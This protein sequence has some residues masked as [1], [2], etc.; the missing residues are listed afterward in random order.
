M[1]DEPGL[2]IDYERDDFARLPLSL[3]VPI[4]RFIQE[5][6]NNVRKH[7]RANRV[8]IRIRLRTDLLLV[9]V[10]DNGEGFD[11]EEA[12][13]TARAGP[14]HHMGLR[15]MRDQIQEA[16]GQWEISSK[17]GEGTTVRARFLLAS[18]PTVLTQRE[19]EVLR[20]L[21]EGLTNRAIA[22]RLS[23]STETI[24]SHVH[25]IMQKLQVN[26]RTQAAVIATKQHWL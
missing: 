7:A 4:F 22:E 11:V 6:L 2:K 1:Y 23:V 25:H 12:L 18:A 26:D 24:K 16:G 9:E 10:N 14:V 20:L 8:V 21:V 19:R 5:A 3:E 15:S 17:S 13:S